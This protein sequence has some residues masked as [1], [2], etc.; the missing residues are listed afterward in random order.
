MKTALKT[1]LI[2]AVLCMLAEGA[3]RLLFWQ[4]DRHA[5]SGPLVALVDQIDSTGAD[6]LYL[7]ES[8]NH[9][10][11]LNDTDTAWISEMVGRHF[12]TLTV[13][14]MTHD[15]SHAEVYYELLRNIDPRCHI[16]TVVVT[17]NLRS[18]GVGW[19]Y[20]PLETALQKRLV[21]MKG[22][23]ALANRA[24]LSFKAY[25]IKTENERYQQMDHY[26]SQHPLPGHP[27]VPR[28]ADSLNT[29]SSSMPGTF[30]RNYAFVIDTME[31]VRIADF[32]NIVQLSRKRG[33]RL[34]F[35]L[36]AEDVEWAERLAGSDLTDLMHANAVLLEEYYTRKGVVVVNNLDA[37]PDSLFRDRDWTTEHYL[38][39]GRQII[40]DKVA[41]AL[42]AFYPTAYQL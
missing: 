18:F 12:P 36:L 25:D 30:V 31:N 32:D 7:G 22:R 33:W 35:N 16:G 37:V 10:F 34:V 20:S 1:L 17:L 2:V 21:M 23:P 11:G 39:Q 19:I 40:A 8:S 27:S 6:I 26:W 38:Q 13:R 9:T 3:Y 28:W 4:H 41:E 24:I 15:A 29:D 5:Y 42:R 14:N